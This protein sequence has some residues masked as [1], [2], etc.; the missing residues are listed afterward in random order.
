MVE[1]VLTPCE[2]L[3]RRLDTGVTLR[4]V[5]TGYC[6]VWALPATTAL[7]PKYKTCERSYRAKLYA[8]LTVCIRRAMQG[9]RALS[10]GYASSG[11]W[12]GLA[13]CMT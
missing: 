6:V 10:V 7:M 1:N 4:A 12:R 9:G 3:R 5:R 8:F 2:A 11:M 13:T